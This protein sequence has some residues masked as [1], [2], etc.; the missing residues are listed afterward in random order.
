MKTLLT[1]FVLLFSSLVV[2]GDDLTGKKILCANFLWA[3]EFNS[4]EKVTV[5]STNINSKT[6]IT[7]F[8]YETM[9]DMPYVKLYLN[10]NY[11][12]NAVFSINRQTLSID[13]WIMTSG[14]NTPR[15][16]IPG[17]FCEVV[18]INNLINYIEDLKNKKLLKEK[19]KNKI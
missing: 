4:S 7:E 5:I 2:A 1:L 8:Y 17:R 3:F 14:G 19:S 9:F 6:N 12:R 11:T 10:K 15:E 13:R 18:Q 16:I